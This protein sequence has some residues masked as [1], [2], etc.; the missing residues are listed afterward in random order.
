MD[1]SMLKVRIQ[2]LVEIDASHEIKRIWF[3]NDFKTLCRFSETKS[4]I[5]DIAIVSTHSSDNQQFIG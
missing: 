5:F 3:E 2:Y 1:V 4:I